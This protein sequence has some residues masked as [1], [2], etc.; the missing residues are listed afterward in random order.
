MSSVD[1]VVV[2]YRSADTIGPCVASILADPGASVTV[3]DNAA[4]PA[5]Q[6][7]CAAFGD[8]VRY[9]VPGANLGYSRAANLGLHDT[10]APLVAIVNPDVELVMTLSNLAAAG[11]LTPTSPDLVSGR[12]AGPP[13][14]NARPR[15]TIRR[16][17]MKALRGPSAYR[18]GP[19]LAP[20]RSVEQ[21][22]GALMLLSRVTWADLGGFDERFELYYEDVDLC[23]RVRRRGGR[24]LL[25]AGTAGNHV[26]GASS[27]VSGAPAFIA[28]RVSRL[29]YLRI[30]HGLLGTSAALLIAVTE[31]LTRSLTA[32]AEGLAARRGALTATWREARRPGSL[33]ILAGAS[34]DTQRVASPRQPRGDRLS[35]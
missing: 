11:R 22:D 6:A 34:P 7:A 19:D 9:I 25:V 26:G 8:R 24:V 23:E 21:V 29:R 15:V 20:L 35:L 14:L 27:R 31:F 4:D 2:A 16:E 30:W 17:L 18:L 3:V 5:T 32:R 12:L 33:A 28:L 1:A 13:S 10:D